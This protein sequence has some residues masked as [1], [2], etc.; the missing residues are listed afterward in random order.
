[1]GWPA[2]A[3]SHPLQRLSSRLPAIVSSASGHAR[4]WGLTLAPAAD[5]AAQASFGT[6]LVLQKF[7][8]AHVGDVDRAAEALERTLI[9]RREFGLETD[10]AGGGA[11]GGKGDETR[12]EGLGWITRVRFEEGG[13]VVVTWNI[14]GAA[15]DDLKG[16]FGDLDSFLHWRVNLMERGVA[17]ILKPVLEA[18]T[19]EQEAALEPIPDYSEGEDPYQGYQVHDYMDISFLRM[20]PSVKAASKATIALMSAHYPE[21]LSRKF[22]VS[23]PLV[24]SWVFSA[25]RLLVSAETARKFTVVSYKSNLAGE[26]SGGA[27][28]RG[29]VRAGDVPVEYGGTGEALAEMAVA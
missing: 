11:E 13:E 4:I 5:G 1:M 25:V 28:G 6:L 24:M 29:R 27:G 17:A 22:F 18:T 19:P 16:V 23:V 7:L 12:F 2:L 14:Y 20:D 9:W 26:L 15:K 21:W 10:G 8:R 3:P